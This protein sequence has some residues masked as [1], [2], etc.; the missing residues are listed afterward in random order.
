MLLRDYIIK[1]G[2]AH[3]AEKFGVKERTVN[4]YKRG[5]RMPKHDIALCIVDATDNVVT[6][7]ECYGLPV[8]NAA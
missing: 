6:Y 8:E 4:A 7:A 2:V 3:C 5:E 1:H